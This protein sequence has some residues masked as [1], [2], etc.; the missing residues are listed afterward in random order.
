VYLTLDVEDE[1]GDGKGFEGLWESIPKD[2]TQ[3]TKFKELWKTIGGTLVD[4]GFLDEFCLDKG[5]TSEEIKDLKRL[6]R[7]WK[8]VGND[9]IEDPLGYLQELDELRRDSETI[10]TEKEEKTKELKKIEGIGKLWKAIDC[11]TGLPDKG[12]TET[13]F[14]A[15]EKHLAIAKEVVQQISGFLPEELEKEYELF[16]ELDSESI[17]LTKIKRQMEELKDF[18]PMKC[19]GYNELSPGSIGD[20]YTREREKLISYPQDKYMKGLEEAI[21]GILEGLK[22]ASSPISVFFSEER[23]TLDYVWEDK[24]GKKGIRKYFQQIREFLPPD[25]VKE[26]KGFE[27]NALSSSTPEAKSDELE[28]LTTQ[29]NLVALKLNLLGTCAQAVTLE[30]VEV[31]ELLNYGISHG[32]EVQHFPPEEISANQEFLLADE[33]GKVRVIKGLEGLLEHINYQKSRGISCLEVNPLW[34]IERTADGKAIKVKTDEGGKY[35]AKSITGI[36]NSLKDLQDMKKKTEKNFDPLGHYIYAERL[37][38]NYDFIPYSKELKRINPEKFEREKNVIMKKALEDAKKHYKIASEEFDVLKEYLK[39]NFKYFCEKDK[40][41]DDLKKLASYLENHEIARSFFSAEGVA[42]V[43]TKKD[44][45]KELETKKQ[46]ERNTFIKQYFKEQLKKCFDKE[47]SDEQIKEIANFVFENKNFNELL[48]NIK[49][50][51]QLENFL[52]ALPK[53]NLLKGLA[54][55]KEF[56]ENI[57][58]IEKFIKE[59]LESVKKQKALVENQLAKAETAIKEKQEK[60][61][62]LA[63]KEFAAKELADL[64][65]EQRSMVTAPKL[66]GELRVVEPLPDLSGHSQV[67]SGKKSSSLYRTGRRTTTSPSV[68]LFDTTGPRRLP[69]LSSPKHPQVPSGIT[70]SSLRRTGGSSRTQHPPQKGKRGRDM[71]GI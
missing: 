43:F 69:P 58:N 47:P 44:F 21:K 57:E 13:V 71:G 67:P 70:G 60:I 64:K 66:L 52:K 5:C 16:K 56:I 3:L 61:L 35:I 30:K 53:V 20:C 51:K 25:L 17:D 39:S 28:K 12:V 54:K 23:K 31:G 9:K 1:P 55:R 37:Y 50:E 45:L 14:K 24:E 62:E 4:E 22:D 46:E 29:V 2:G 63:A 18:L 33:K 48:K 7:L 36:Y 41:S 68:T 10:T 15:V 32:L 11:I 65:V 6:K 27:E 42:E 34:P 49:E 40:D 19:S 59:E 26:Y 8:I 38:Y